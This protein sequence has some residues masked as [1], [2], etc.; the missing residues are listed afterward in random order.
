[1]L[2][3]SVTFREASYDLLSRLEQ[4]LDHLPLVCVAWLIEWT[5]SDTQQWIG[6]DELNHWE[7]EFK[8]NGF[9]SS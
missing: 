7:E 1:M 4:I 2:D 8:A 3:I 5:Q 6:L 9:I